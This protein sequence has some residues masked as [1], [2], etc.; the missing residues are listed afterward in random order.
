MEELGEER[1]ECAPGHDDGPFGAERASRSNGDRRGNGLQDRHLGLDA[2]A[3][4]KDGFE[5]LRD[6]VSANLGRAP[7]G[8]GADD[9][10]ADHGN[11]DAPDSERV[12]GGRDEM[13]RKSLVVSEIRDHRDQPDQRVGD[14]SAD[15]ADAD[16]R[17]RENQNTPIGRVVGEPIR[18]R[19]AQ[20]V[21]PMST[22]SVFLAA[23]KRAAT[24]FQSQ[25][26]QIAS[27]NSVLRFW[28]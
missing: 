14:Q 3:P 20:S 11:S 5:R 7:S 10:S 8:H 16:G 25:T 22:A 9:E 21:A 18:A 28:Y 26:F 6:A 19:C 2:A 12:S 27:K 4:D 23:S 24:S 15:G 13:R 17:G 1:A